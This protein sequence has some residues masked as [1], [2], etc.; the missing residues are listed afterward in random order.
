MRV[1]RGSGRTGAVAVLEHGA[2]RSSLPAS[3]E[4]R[5]ISLRIPRLLAHGAVRLDDPVAPTV[6]TRFY[7]ERSNYG[8]SAQ[9]NLLE[10]AL[11]AEAG[12]YDSRQDRSGTD[13][14]VPNSQ[15]RFLAGYHRELWPDFTAG[16]QVYGEL[17]ANYAAYRRSLPPGAPHQ[18][19]FRGV[20][21]LRL[22]RLLDYQAW[23]PY[24][25]TDEDYT[26]VETTT[27]SLQVDWTS[28]GHEA[29]HGARADLAAPRSRARSTPAVFR[30]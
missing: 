8:A 10:R 22:T 21:S 13:P 4:L 6:A 27:C 9:R 25:P 23:R 7:P 24:S 12:Y 5:R 28:D 16:V 18:D 20:L 17:M 30:G 11:S 19:E 15:W 2:R 29:K 14:T 26:S 1:S 3:G